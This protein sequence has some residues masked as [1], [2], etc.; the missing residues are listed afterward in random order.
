MTKVEPRHRVDPRTFS[1]TINS[2]NMSE[3]LVLVAKDVTVTWDG[4][5][6]QSLPITESK[7]CICVR[8]S[9]PKPPQLYSEQPSRNASIVIGRTE[10]HF[11]IICT[12]LMNFPEWFL[13]YILSHRLQPINPPVHPSHYSHSSQEDFIQL[14][15]RVHSYYRSK[16]FFAYGK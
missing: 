11:D 8:G 6:K 7:S 12:Y 1:L 14:A 13:W 15:P 2:S 5:R 16:Y 3:T 4:C 10:S 9:V